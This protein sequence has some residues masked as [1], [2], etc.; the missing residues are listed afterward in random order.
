MA[1]SFVD[2][3][4]LYQPVLSDGIFFTLSSNTYDA[5]STFKF[6]FVYSLYINGA[7]E[8]EA[9]C[10]PNPY[11][12][13]I[14]DLQ[15]I[16]ESYTNSSPISYWNTTPIYAH[17]SFPFS[18]PSNDETIAYQ[19]KVG[20]EYADSETSPITGFTG[21]GN[22]IGSPAVESDIY[23]V[24]RS[25][26]GTNGRA[27]Q[28]DFDFGPFIMS[29]APSGIYPTTSGLFLTNAPRIMD[30]SPED[31][32]ILGFSN[33]YLNSGYTT[34]G[35][36]VLSEPYY[37]EYKFYDND[38]GLISTIQYDNVLGNGGG[39]RSSGCDVYPALYLIDPWSGTN[40]NTLYVGAGP[41]NLPILPDNCA[42]Y[43][44]QLFGV[45]EGSTSPIQPTPTPTPTPSSTPVL[46]PSITPTQTPQ[47]AN[48]DRYTIEYT[49]LS[50][51]GSATYVD[52]SDGTSKNFKPLPTVI[53]VVCS[54]STPTGLDLDV[55]YLEPCTPPSPSPTPAAC[56]CIEYLIENEEPFFDTIQWQDCY[57]N[58]QSTSLGSY[59]TITLCACEGTVTA[60]YSFISDLGECIPATPTPTPSPTGI[61]PT[62]TP[63]STSGY[64]Y[65]YLVQDC[66]DPGT[67]LCF[68]SNTFYPVG[69]VVKGTI[70]TGC[71]EILD[72]CSAPEDDVITLSYLSCGV[73]P[74]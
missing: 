38:G 9:K 53:Y 60:N 8:F 57:G 74:R 48:C 27:T 7:L 2:T 71:F 33:Y 11:G 34:S 37:V 19:I 17:Q 58:Y 6:R 69:R 18:R 12:L 32:F 36:T 3:P 62:P 14:V 54:C 35:N 42:Q 39:P 20:Y 5:Q 61:P 24:F 55:Q 73:C 65:Y 59:Q 25:T 21:Y 40:Y 22:I 64:G 15:Q 45:F 1:I 67:Q 46:T 41:A 66:D 49:G 63:T 26:M 51:F 30:V 28:Q 31:Y 52:C 47:C 43:T 13:G 4:A 44:V 70:I 29:G 23:K 68:A 10:S 56:S 16:L 72:F 50:E